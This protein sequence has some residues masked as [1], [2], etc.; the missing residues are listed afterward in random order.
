[1]AGHIT[2]LAQA[3]AD[4]L[5]AGANLK[6][7]ADALFAELGTIDEAKVIDI[8]TNRWL[9]A[10]PGYGPLSDPTDHLMVAGRL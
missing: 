2:P 9:V 10:L 5:T 6:A 8:G 1:M 4:A 7:A 3:V